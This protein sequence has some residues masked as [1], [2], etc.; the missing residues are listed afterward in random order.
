MHKILGFTSFNDLF[1]SL[2]QVKDKMLLF[3]SI[4]FGGATF[5]EYFWHDPRQII[6]LWIM[7]LLD[8]IT[9]VLCAIKFKTFTSRRLPRWAGI[10]FSYSL[11]LFLS[12]NMAKFNEIFF[13]LPG[14]L[15]GLFMAVQFKSLSENL[16]KL[17][18]LNIPLLK[19]INDKIERLLNSKLDDDESSDKT[20]INKTS[21]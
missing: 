13:W 20:N 21:E 16:G 10:V 12:Y 1:L 7:L 18:W 8:L 2:F 11:L 6:F 19:K 4:I 14:S 9:G 17:K 15:Y 5:T 3:F